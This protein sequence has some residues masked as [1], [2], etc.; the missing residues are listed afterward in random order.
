[1][2]FPLLAKLSN[3]CDTVIRI[4]DHRPQT[5]DIRPQTEEGE[6]ARN[7]TIGESGV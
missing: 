5:S 1:M 6:I 3:G 4:V 2:K 7:Y